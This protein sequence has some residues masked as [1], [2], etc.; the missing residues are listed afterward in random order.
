MLGFGQQV[1]R[2][3]CFGVDYF[4]LYYFIIDSF[5]GEGNYLI[6]VSRFKMLVKGTICFIGIKTQKHRVTVSV[7]CLPR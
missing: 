4:F 3:T 5:V 6:E 7:P 1:S 2:K